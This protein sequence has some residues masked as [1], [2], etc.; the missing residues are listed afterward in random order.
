LADRTNGE[1]VLQGGDAAIDEILEL[2][3][4]ALGAESA[5]VGVTVFRREFVLT[6]L[7]LRHRLDDRGRFRPVEKQPGRRRTVGHNRLTR[8][9]LAVGNNRGSP[10]LRLDD[11]DPEILFGG[12]DKGP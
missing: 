9:A 11:D 10:A 6:L 2:A 3:V 8:P 4:E 7:E 12:K 5:G 1:F